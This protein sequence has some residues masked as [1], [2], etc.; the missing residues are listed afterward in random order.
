MRIPLAMTAISILQSINCCFLLFASPKV[1]AAT[2]E[3][4]VQFMEM[5]IKEARKRSE[6]WPFLIAVNPVDVPDYRKVI[7]D[8]IDISLIERRLNSRSYYISLEIFQADW[9]RMFDNCRFYNAENTI[10]YKLAD[11]LEKFISK[12]MDAR[13]VR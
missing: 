8:P 12:L 1:V 13:V 10:Y 9:T 11:K 7:K 5:V 6:V 3:K 4:L 2:P